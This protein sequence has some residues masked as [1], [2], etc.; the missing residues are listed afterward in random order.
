M[1]YMYTC[2]VAKFVNNNQ[3]ATVASYVIEIM[4]M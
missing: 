1:I 4:M 2:A 3:N